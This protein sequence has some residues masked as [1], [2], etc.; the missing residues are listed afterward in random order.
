MAEL[1][2]EA[3]RCKISI[4]VELRQAG[5]FMQGVRRM[6]QDRATRLEMEGV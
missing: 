1:T 4:M 6:R 2:Y 5:S 3:L